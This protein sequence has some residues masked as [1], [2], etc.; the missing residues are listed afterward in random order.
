ME[1]LTGMGF[2]P[3]QC[4]LALGVA[5]GSV[6]GAL[7]ILLN[8]EILEL[9]TSGLARRG[10]ALGPRLGLNLGDRPDERDPA[11]PGVEVSPE[12]MA[13]LMEMGYPP[14]RCSKSLFQ[15]GGDVERA[16]MYML[17]NSHESDEFWIF[18]PDEL[19]WAIE[20]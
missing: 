15:S 19:A 11:P 1:Q 6:E 17:E 7:Q 4:T 13:A 14:V 3:E 8:P 12:S 10:G 5:R 16:A 2:T 20:L 9:I 18:T